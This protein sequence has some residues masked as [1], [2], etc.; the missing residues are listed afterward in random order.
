MNVT[1]LVDKA[2]GY[3]LVTRV[4]IDAEIGRQT[5][6]NNFS[7][8]REVGLFGDNTSDKAVLGVSR[9]NQI[10]IKDGLVHNPPIDVGPV[11][12]WKPCLSGE[13]RHPSSDDEI[14]KVSSVARIRSDF[15]S[16]GGI[17]LQACA[18]TTRRTR[19]GL[20]RVL[21]RPS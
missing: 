11:P 15:E 13:A 4:R 5:A 9:N 3:A 1:Q 18:S 12:Q 19:G 2:K 21:R 6:G 17:Q 10:A 7:M 14:R 16:H 8:N 20:T